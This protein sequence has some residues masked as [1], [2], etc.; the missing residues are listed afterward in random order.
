[1]N[2]IL[3]SNPQTH[4][5]HHLIPT[6]PHYHAEEATIAIRPVLGEHYRHDDTSMLK[7]I[8]RETKECIFVEADEKSDSKGILW[9]RKQ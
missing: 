9:F 5:L 6:I 8:W 2:S 1:M 3:H 7:A 4:V